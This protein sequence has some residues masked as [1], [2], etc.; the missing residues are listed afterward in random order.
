MIA[1]SKIFTDAIFLN[2]VLQRRYPNIS[3]DTD[4]LV[5]VSTKDGAL[6][7]IVNNTVIGE[8]KGPLTKE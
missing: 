1:K 7:V 8:Y 2:K 4:K 6:V 3:L 5:I